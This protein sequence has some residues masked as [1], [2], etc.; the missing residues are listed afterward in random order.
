MKRAIGFFIGLLAFC[1]TT[2]TFADDLGKNFEASMVVTGTI[3]VNP[4]GSVASYTL[5]QPDKLP[6]AATKIASATLPKWKFQPVLED[7]KPVSAK[8]LMS[9]RIVAHPIDEQHAS[10]R[11][12]G[13]EFGREVAQDQDKQSFECANG[14]CLI[15]RKRRPPSY[16][17]DAI[18]NGVS[19]TVYVVQEVNRDGHV[20][21][22]DVRQTN[23]R[24]RGSAADVRHW[25]QMF[26]DASLA[27]ARDWTYQ[28]PTSGEE[29]KRDHWVVLVPVN[30]MI[31]DY[32]YAYGQWEPYIPGPVQD[33]PWARDDEHIA[34]SGGSDAIPA[35]GNAFVADSRFVLLTPLDGDT[36]P[37]AP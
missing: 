4:D 12:S 8:S 23:L 31:G 6:P 22:Q 19:G 32:E 29:A 14:A 10:V 18:R 21:R 11:I 3:T 9:L 15:A 17:V 2:V 26:D 27:V 35:N 28:I 7:G 13:A 16:P 1:A 25:S 20:E 37:G 33:I 5:D 34:S 30:F 24:N 36:T